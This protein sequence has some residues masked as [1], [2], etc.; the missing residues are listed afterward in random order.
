MAAYL[1]LID[2]SLLRERLR[3]GRRARDRGFRAASRRASSLIWHSPPRRRSL[4]LVAGRS[5]RGPRRRAGLLRP[6]LGPVALGRPD[7]RFF[8]SVVRVQHDRGHGVVS[9][10]PYRLVRH[11]V[12]LGIPDCDRQRVG[13][14]PKPPR[15]VAGREAARRRAGPDRRATTSRM[16]YVRQNTDRTARGATRR[17]RPRPPKP[18]RRRAGPG[19]FQ[20]RSGRAAVAVRRTAARS[21]RNDSATSR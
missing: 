16:T 8:S 13:R 3:P 1:A 2:S 11:P 21:R 12:Y 7:Q 17:R 19:S 9:D 5:R 4:P 18:P 14:P 6:G 20:R 15:R 10:G